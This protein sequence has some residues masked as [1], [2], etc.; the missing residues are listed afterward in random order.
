MKKNLTAK[1]K[2]NLSKSNTLPLDF[3]PIDNTETQAS[4]FISRL[5]S[6]GFINRNKSYL[7]N[8]INA[9]MGIAFAH[10]K[11]AYVKYVIEGGWSEEK[12][13]SVLYAIIDKNNMLVPNAFFKVGIQYDKGKVRG[14]EDYNSEPSKTYTDE[15][16]IAYMASVLEEN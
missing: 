10:I 3:T 6:S 14:T 16:L 15:D 8:Y 7:S 11:N 9:D 13:E 12:F 1:N 2:K 4:D 5:Q